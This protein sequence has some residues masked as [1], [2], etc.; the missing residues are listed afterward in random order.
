MI[1]ISLPFG[2]FILPWSLHPLEGFPL[3]SLGD[4]S[5]LVLPFLLGD[6]PSFPFPLEVPFIFLGG[7][8]SPS[9]FLRRPLL[10]LGG[11]PSFP[12]R[13]VPEQPTVR[14]PS[15]LKEA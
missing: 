14:Q 15:Q 4:S 8:I 11:L 6:S 5:L 3:F 7:S 13:E 9:P 12:S 10:P 2:E 1:L